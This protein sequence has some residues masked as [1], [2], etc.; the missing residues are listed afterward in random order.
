MLGLERNQDFRVRRA[1]SAAV[2]VGKIDSAGRQADVI[3][4]AREFRG[5]YLPANYALNLIGE[6][7]GSFDAAAGLGAHMQTDL[8]GVD[9]RKEVLPEDGNE[10]ETRHAKDE[11]AGGEGAPVLQAQAEQVRILVPQRLEAVLETTVYAREKS[12]PLLRLGVLALFH[13]GAQQ[14]HDERGNQR[15]REE[16]RSQ[17]SEYDGFGERHEEI[18]GHTRQEKHGHEHDAD[19][20]GGD[21]RGNRDLLRSIENALVEIFALAELP[22]DILDGDGGVIDQNSDRQ[23]EAAQ[24]HDVDGFPDGTEN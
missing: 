4:N 17:Q 9:R 12:G 23:R 16:I 3:E 19:A 1:D 18:T 20:E 11:K 8:A 2:A 22:L 6:G 21:E 15:S 5:R 13:F 14:I 24:R 10:S 7:C